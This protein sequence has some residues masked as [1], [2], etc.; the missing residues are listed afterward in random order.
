MHSKS[1]VH[2]ESILRAQHEFAARGMVVIPEFVD[3]AT[4]ERLTRF[5]TAEM[6][7]DWWFA[8]TYPGMA[9]QRIDTR[10]VPENV[11]EVARQ[12]A[13]AQARFAAGGFAYAFFRTLHHVAGCG[14]PLCESISLLEGPEML[15]RI[16]G[17]TGLPITRSGGL[18]ASDYTPTS[19]LSPH[20]DQ[21]NGRVALV[22][23][24][25]QNWRPQFG[26]LLHILDDD[27]EEVRGIIVPRFN[28]AALFAVPEPYGTPHFVS[29]VASGVGARRLAVS[30]WYA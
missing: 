11:G 21:D 3:V 23:Q 10:N 9:E 12:Y 1:I 30:G 4:A 26:G 27:W 22:W 25:T 28:S 7:S 15:A 24:L 16:A 29:Q 2:S 20:T 13:W 17:I 18:F 5:L 14:C 19:F 6:P 8:S